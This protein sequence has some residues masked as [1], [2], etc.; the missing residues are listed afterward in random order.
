VRNGIQYN[1]D[2][3]TVTLAAC[4]T[5]RSGAWVSDQVLI[6]VRDSGSGIP[7]A[8]RER[9]FERFYRTDASRSRRTGGAGL[10]LAI[11]REIIRLF[12][13]TIRVADMPGPGTTIEVALPGGPATR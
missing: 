5:P 12:K 13:G 11:S 2:G 7:P 4:I 6:S 1:R 10:G 3:G 8:E 9:V